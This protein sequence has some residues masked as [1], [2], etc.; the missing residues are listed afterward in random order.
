[1]IPGKPAD[2]YSFVQSLP[3]LPHLNV[4]NAQ[5]IIVVNPRVV[6]CKVNAS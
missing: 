2:S 5:S 6:T 3:F 1:M 4:Q